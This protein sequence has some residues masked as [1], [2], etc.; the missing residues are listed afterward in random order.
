MKIKNRKKSKRK[1][2]EPIKAKTSSSRSKKPLCAPFRH[3]RPRCPA[4]QTR[5]PPKSSVDDMWG[6]FVGL[7]FFP[8]ETNTEANGDRDFDGWLE[9]S[10]SPVALRPGHK[11]C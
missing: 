1:K 11:Y 8:V 3:R 4:S 5:A 9:S 6:P 2:E 7:V 10:D